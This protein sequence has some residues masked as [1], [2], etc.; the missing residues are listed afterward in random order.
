MKKLIFNTG[1]MKYAKLLFV[2]ILFISTYL[3]AQVFTNSPLKATVNPDPNFHIYIYMFWAVEYG[4]ERCYSG[5]RQD[6]S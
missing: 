3:P 2:S 4:R 5:F 1:K 6:W